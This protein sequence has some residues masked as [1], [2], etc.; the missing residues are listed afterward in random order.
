MSCIYMFILFQSCHSFQASSPWTQTQLVM[1]LTS[2]LCNVSKTVN[3][4]CTF[5]KIILTLKTIFVL[6]GI[7]LC[8]RIDPE[9]NGRVTLIE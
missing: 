9:A 8:T 7:S 1:F 4:L 6:I 3:K 2:V 5:P